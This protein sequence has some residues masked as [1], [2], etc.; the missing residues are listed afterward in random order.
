MHGVGPAQV[1]LPEDPPHTR[2]GSPLV[3]PCN[4]RATCKRK[5]A[6]S[7]LHGFG[8]LP[9]QPTLGFIILKGRAALQGQPL[10]RNPF[11]II[12]SPCF[13]R[14]AATVCPATLKQELETH[15]PVGF[16]L[17]FKVRGNAWIELPARVFYTAWHGAVCSFVWHQLNC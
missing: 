3:S 16:Q 10:N 17:C 8:W 13:P 5:E 2:K 15:W 4:Q 1:W 7:R 12:V 9:L 11:S 14:R 6:P